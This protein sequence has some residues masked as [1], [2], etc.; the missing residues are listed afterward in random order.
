MLRTKLAYHLAVEKC[1]RKNEF[2][3][4]V[5]ESQVSLIYSKT[6]NSLCISAALALFI[7][8]YFWCSDLCIYLFIF[9]F[10][11]IRWTRSNQKSNLK[12]YSLCNAWFKL[13][14]TLCMNAIKKNPYYRAQLFI[15]TDSSLQSFACIWKRY[16]FFKT[17]KYIE[18]NNPSPVFIL[19]ISPIL[20]EMLIFLQW[21][22]ANYILKIFLVTP[23]AYPVNTSLYEIMMVM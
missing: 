2:P 13:K 11:M 1:C 17:I 7:F 10:E 12:H 19:A 16:S 4:D 8:H 9:I 23:C 3:V 14:V 6:D 20:N 5:V 21:W 15:V 18:R 22:S